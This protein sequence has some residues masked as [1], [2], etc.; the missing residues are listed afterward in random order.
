MRFFTVFLFLLTGFTGL[1]QETITI[2]VLTKDFKTDKKDAGVTVKVYDGSTLVQT[3]VSNAA[4]KAVFNL[5]VNKVYKVE[6]SKSGKVSRFIMVNAKGISPEL[7]PANS[8][9]SATFSIGLFEQVPGVDFS[10]ISSEKATEFYFDGSNPA[11]SFDDVVA[12]RMA[13]KIDKLLKDAD[14]KKGASDAQYNAAIKEADAFFAQKKYNEAKGS[15]EKALGFKPTEQYPAQKL[16]DI[17]NILRSQNQSNSAAA[18]AES[19]YKALIES[20]DNL[21][22]QKKYDEAIARYKE[23]YAKKPEPYAQTQITKAEAEIARLKAEAAN[24]EKYNAAIQRADGFMKQSSFQAARDGYKEALKYKKDDP[25]ATGKLAELE[26]KLNA[27]KTEQDKKKKYDD[28]VAAADALMTEEKWADAKVKYNEALAIEASSAYAKGK[29]AEADAKLAEIEK[30]KQKQEQIAKLL[31]EGNAAFAGSKWAESKAKF[32]EVLKLDDKNAV[33][34]AK[35]PEIDAKLADEKAN[36][37]KIA[38]VKQ[39]VADGDVLAKQTKLA[40][41]KA[42]YEEAQ[43]IIPDAAVKAKI[44][45]I[46]AQLADASKKAEQKAKYD[47]A[48]A[49]GD[50]AMAA[51]KFEDAIAKYTEA[52]TLDPAQ[53]APKTK[54][55]EAQKKIDAAKAAADKDQKYAAALAAGVAAMDA[56][57]Y[58]EAKTKLQEAIGIDGTKPEAKAKMTELEGILAGQ[59]K[60][61]EL[62]A[63]V[64]A[65]VKAGDDLVSANKL[66]EAKAKYVEAQGVK[67]SQEVQEKIADIDKTLAAAEQDKA[68]K[69]ASY[70]KAMADGETLFAAAKY[71]EAKG[72][73][74]EALAIDDTQTKPKDRIIDADKKIA[75]GLAAADKKQKFDAAMA[76]GA[77]ALTAKDLAG[78]KTKYQEALT[79]E[80]SSADAKAKLAEVEGLIAA[81]T[82]AKADETKRLALIKAGDELKAGGKSLDAKAKYTESLAISNDPAVVAK[83][84]AIDSEIAAAEGEKA[85]KQAKYNGAMSEGEALAGSGK[86]A[87]AKN[88]FLEAGTIDPSQAAPKQ[89][90]ADMD[91]KIAEELANNEKTAKYQAA[92]DAGVAAMGSNDL[93]AAKTKFTEAL[94]IDG[95]KPEAKAKLAEVEALISGNAK[96]AETEK[97]YADAIKA[98]SDLVTA[99]KLAEAKAKFQEAKTLKPS[100]SLPDQKIAEID[101]QLA[102][103]E[104]QKQIDDA[105]KAANTSFDKK[106]YQ[107][108]KAGY[109]NVLTL[110]PGN[111]TAAAKLAD[112]A[113]IESEQA[114]AAQNDTKFKQLKDEGVALMGSQDYQ[115]AKQKFLEAKA[116][117]SDPSIDDLIKQADAKI[118]ELAKGAE[119]DQKYAAALQA[120]QTFENDKKYDEAIAKYN[121]ALT[122]KNEQLPK[123]RIAAINKIKSDNAAQAKIDA[124]YNAAMK[125]G[126]EMMAG[127]DYLKAIETY[128]KALAIKPMEKEPADK[129]AEAERLEKERT[130]G[131]VE[132]QYQKLL[133]VA[134]KSLDE[135][136]YT[137]AKELYTRAVGLK[138]D[139]PFPKEKLKEIETALK[140]EKEAADKQTAFN[141]KMKEGEGAV[142]KKDYQGAISFFEAAKA[143][144][145]DELAPDQRIS[146]IR[147]LMDAESNKNAEAEAKYA[148]L[149]ADG[150]TLADSKDYRSAIGKYKDAL[151]VKP[152]DKP[153]S[154]KIAAMESKLNELAEKEAS[155]AKV[156]KIIDKADKLFGKSEWMDAKAV[157]EE[158]L[159]VAPSN[160]YAQAQVKKC[161]DNASADKK[162]ELDKAYSKLIAKADEKF[163]GA[164]YESA[165]DYYQRAVKAKPSDPYPKQRLNEIAARMNKKEKPNNGQPEELASLGDPGSEDSYAK[166]VEAE[167]ERE[168]RKAAKV[169]AITSK[170]ELA[171]DS[172]SNQNAQNSIEAGVALM[173]TKVNNEGTEQALTEDQK[174][175]IEGVGQLDNEIN[176]TNRES[177]DFESNSLLY[178][179]SQLALLNQE[180][181]QALQSLEGGQYVNHEGMTAVSTNAEDVEAGYQ[182][183]AYDM[184]VEDQQKFTNTRIEIQNQDLDDF[185]ERFE[186]TEKVKETQNNITAVNEASIA[187]KNEELLTFQGELDEHNVLVGNKYEEDAKIAPN[188]EEQIKT[189]TAEVV[190]QNISNDEQAMNNSLTARSSIE[191]VD[192][193]VSELAAQ[194]DETRQTNVAEV[195]DYEKMQAQRELDE[196]NASL[197]KS[198]NTNGQLADMSKAKSELELAQEKYSSDNEAKIKEMR[199]E[200]NKIDEA[201]AK[202]K[203][204]QLFE[205]QS[206]LEDDKKAT[207]VTSEPKGANDLG[208]LYKE[209]VTEIPYEQ[210]DEEG[211]LQAVVTRRIVVK[212][213]HGDEYIRTQTLGGVTYTKNGQA[214]TEYNWQKETNDAAL[215]K[216]TP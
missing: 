101:Q 200:R 144:K 141:A 2:D 120:A 64:A 197:I 109:Q 100:E 179:D 180:N 14:A 169:N 4:G 76:A 28:A 23:A 25:Y 77:T 50:A 5:P 40:E 146:D 94:A 209:G 56:K 204:E 190:K 80:N 123:E 189:L 196:Y 170:P 136:N 149:M 166:L 198:Y 148:A 6:A 165:K 61:K 212:Q 125:K 65:L 139:D 83:I 44:D 48:M 69:K 126:D 12:K 87:D 34:L 135:K 158:A 71:E 140:T 113:K 17:D 90:V 45:A 62:D 85:A 75:E 150:N 112:I 192:K 106:D 22:G 43:S 78:A 115:G 155:D 13:A 82:K 49:D 97:K 53:A 214:I 52:Q 27:Q 130:G 191:Q 187:A 121:E 134:Q 167:N 92:F 159:A 152:N 84:N 15:Y 132:A 21:Y 37:D 181:T 98:G 105:L 143:I 210:K 131:D 203:T 177:S 162:Q 29:I 54:I 118:A 201:A 7:L 199:S 173:E 79:I 16:L 35:I 95:T 42:K 154:D 156:Q 174:A 46:D 161:D 103:K 193:T 9:P 30:E 172:L 88:K 66:P 205:A 151:K 188:N 110:D 68:A 163:A 153:A 63:K 160:K 186:V 1:S 11:L 60:E 8:K 86:F 10:S 102:G 18:E 128:N 182:R 67:S 20:A 142:S 184:H 124:D 72:K 38:K 111:A 175:N 122:Y 117:K 119:A 91:K 26:G 138:A 99:G 96:A 176:Q 147:A 207:A 32:Q 107:G 31:Q 178:A 215:T 74:N 195:Q 127:K 157:Y 33:A 114:S 47:K 55:A 145:P 164:D 3:Q 73:F 58:A 51:S 104:K 116:V 213:G 206:Q 89:R 39:L 93:A 19:A 183:S 171:S 41:A 81:D 59:A 168:R 211:L 129:A 24:V 202:V 185:N 57:N 70:D 36:A 208:K 108:A 133:A 216:N 194:T 137:K